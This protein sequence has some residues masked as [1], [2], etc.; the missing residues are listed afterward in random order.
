[1]HRKWYLIF[2]LSF[3]KIFWWWHFKCRVECIPNSTTTFDWLV[4]I[5][6]IEL[7]RVFRNMCWLCHWLFKTTQVYKRL[8]LALWS[9][10]MCYRPILGFKN[11][12]PVVKIKWGLRINTSTIIFPK[13]VINELNWYAV[14]LGGLYNDKFIL[15]WCLYIL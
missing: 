4:K 2:K 10:G 9:W 13:E 7:K 5:R 1:M 14:L 8:L 12:A 15:L 6:S 3:E 11:W